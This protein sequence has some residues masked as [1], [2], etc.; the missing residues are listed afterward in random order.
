MMSI[1]TMSSIGRKT[2]LII[3]I[4]H[5][6]IMPSAVLVNVVALME[7]LTRVVLTLLAELT[8]V[9]PKEAATGIEWKKEPTWAQSYKTFYGRNL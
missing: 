4:K 3:I 7:L 2:L 9:L 5:C 8:A 1:F 6:V